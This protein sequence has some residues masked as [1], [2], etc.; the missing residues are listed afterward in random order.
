ML[1][2]IMG[3]TFSTRNLIA[4]EIRVR[5]HLKFVIDNW[6]LSDLAFENKH[7]LNFIIT[8]LAIGD[9]HYNK[10]ETIADIERKIEVLMDLKEKQII[11]G[12]KNEINKIQK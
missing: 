7:K 8:A 10:E 6:Y 11:N 2:A 12:I 9:G 1:I 4:S 5:D 3:N